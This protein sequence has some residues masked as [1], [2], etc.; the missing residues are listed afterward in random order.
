MD[1]RD[2]FAADLAPLQHALKDID[3]TINAVPVSISMD[4]M[5]GTDDQN[6]ALA[7]DP[8]GDPPRLASLIDRE[9]LPI[10]PNPDNADGEED[11]DDYTSTDD[12]SD[13]DAEKFAEAGETPEE[14]K[15][16]RR[17]RVRKV[18]KDKGV[19]KK[20]LRRGKGFEYPEK[21]FEVQV[22]YIGRLVE[23]GKEEGT[24]REFD[25]C[26]DR[27]RP[28]TFF[29]GKGQVIKGWNR[30]IRTMKK[31]E[32]SRVTIQP[33]YAY[34]EAGF[35]DVIPPNATLEFEIE[36]LGWKNVNALSKD[37]KVTIKMLKESA[38]GWQTP[39][40]GWEVTVNYI[41]KCD[42]VEFADVKDHTFIVTDSPDAVGDTPPYFSLAI[43]KFKKASNEVAC[44]VGLITIMPPHR[45]PHPAVKEGSVVTYEV[46]LVEWTVIEEI[47]GSTGRECIKRLVKEA[48]KGWEKPK[49]GSVVKIRMVGK[50]RVDGKVFVKVGK[51]P[52][53]GVE[54]VAEGEEAH[55]DE[56]KLGTNQLPEAVEVGLT[57]MREGESASIVATKPEWGYGFAQTKQ[58]GVEETGK[59][60]YIFDVTLVKIVEKGKES[61]DLKKEDKLAD[62]EQSKEEG[63]V[64]FK[65]GKYRAA[66]RKYEKALKNFQYD[67]KL[68]RDEKKKVEAMKLPTYLNL[69]ACYLKLDQNDKVVENCTKVALAISSHSV[70]ALYR[71]A[72]A[73]LR[74]VEL[75]DA[76]RDISKALEIDG[77]DPSLKLLSRQI[78]V[79]MKKYEKKDKKV[80]Q[81]M[82]K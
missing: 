64:Y 42:G 36:L 43:Q 13:K 12:D 55:D 51:E 73:R 45:V 20:I 22:N 11:D 46:S 75:D 7:A 76:L 24:G 74:R 61:H 82:F 65:D 19:V 69:A 41:A 66:I 56:F 57:T 35:G 47:E 37:G 17:G 27:E 34:G 25:R 68:E 50:T 29:V 59:S 10:A 39:K 67:N 81:R 28:F 3:Q 38:T 16:R 15:I 23:E 26:Q 72:Q 63:N 6:A 53:A 18:T 71:R 80:Y 78:E 31:G 14:K 21:H 70:K 8:S 40:A 58:Y 52:V 32:I 62:S 54:A 4:A 33:K 48:E 5:S 9:P 1:A 77:S 2:S 60:G 30:A 49:D 79:E 44:D